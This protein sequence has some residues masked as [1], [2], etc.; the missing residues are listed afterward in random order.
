[1]KKTGKEQPKEEISPETK[2][3]GNS[4]T[5]HKEIREVGRGGL[6]SRPCKKESTVSVVRTLSKA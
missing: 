1:M 6:L 2:N 3:E 4:I 5:N